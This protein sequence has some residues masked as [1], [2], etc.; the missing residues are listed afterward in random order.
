[1]TTGV[2]QGRSQVSLSYDSPKIL[3]H[4][5]AI[6]IYLSVLLSFSNAINALCHY[7]LILCHSFIHSFIIYIFLCF[8]LIP[9]CL[10]SPYSCC[11][12]SFFL[13]YFFS[14]HDTQQFFTWLIKDTFIN[15][16]INT[17]RKTSPLLT[18]ITYSPPSPP[19]LPPIKYLS[20]L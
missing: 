7:L 4:I 12:G 11:C 5:L 14:P 16:G 8:S 17:S 13:C 6:F 15:A 3:Q 9:C 1:M 19:P 20:S 18:T 2:K 10:L